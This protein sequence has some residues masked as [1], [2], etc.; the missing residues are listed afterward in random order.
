MSESNKNK[1]IAKNTAFM[2]IRMIFLMLISLYTVRVVLKYLG[3]EDYGILNLIGG[4][5]ALFSFISNSSGA[6]TQRYLNFALGENNLEKLQRVYSASIIIHFVVALIVLLLSEIAGIWAVNCY[7][8]IPMERINAANWVLQFSLFTIVLGIIR[9]PYNAVIVAYEKMSFYAAQSIFEGVCKFGIAFLIAIFPYDKLI[10]YSILIFIVS[11]LS[12]F[13]GK[14]YVN[15]KFP[16]CRFRFHKEKI[17][18]KELVSFS[19]WSLLS[20]IGSTCSNQVLT[21]ILNKFFG[22]IANA[23]LGFA[24][25]VNNAVYQLI[26]NF[27]VAFEPQITKSYAAN[28]RDYLIDLIYKTSKFSFFLLWFFVLPLGLN[29]EIVLKVWLETV[30]DYSVVFLRLIL[31]LSLIE[32]IIG[33]LWMVSYAIGNIRNYQI[34]ALIISLITVPVAWLLFY[35]GFKPYWIIIIRVISNLLFS[36]WR[37]GYLYKRMNFPVWNY[38]KMVLIPSLFVVVISF[39]VSY[40]VFFITSSNIIIQFF[41]S[42]TVTVLANIVCMW[43]IGCNQSEREFLIALIKKI[44]KKER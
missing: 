3:V 31:F 12:F 43:I 18:Y 19:G 27:Q 41:V 33:P 17:L 36:M 44:I 10:F 23:A 30:P 34:V 6:A 20:S 15:I 1:T 14:A 22:V 4:V 11:F 42:C 21:M 24:N 38:L 32:S 9:I 29:A 7:L 39:C 8:N 37:M 26:S 35:L 2:Y 13:I 25:Q 28:D 16:I 40:G 5:V